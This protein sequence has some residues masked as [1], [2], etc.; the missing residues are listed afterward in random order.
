MMVNQAK[1]SDAPGQVAQV[2][3][4]LNF[5]Q[6]IRFNPRWERSDTAK[7]GYASDSR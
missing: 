1:A 5:V 2:N 4:W 3:R 6:E 7:S